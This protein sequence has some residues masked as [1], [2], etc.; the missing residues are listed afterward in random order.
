MVHLRLLITLFNCFTV[1]NYVFEQKKERKRNE[2]QTSIEGVEE[3]EIDCQINV[4]KG[5]LSSSFQR[6]GIVY[7]L[8]PEKNWM[9]E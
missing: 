7:L 8:S 4:H 9:Y 1:M 2:K 6:I 3:E 5:E